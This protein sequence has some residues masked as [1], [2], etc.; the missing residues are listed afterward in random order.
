[1]VH[2]L[3]RLDILKERLKGHQIVLFLDYD[4]TLTPIADR[5]DQAVL[6]LRMRHV[7]NGLAQNK[8]FHIFIVSGRSM[9]DI[10]QLV[11]INNIVHIG[12]HG[13]E[14]EGTDLDFE[15]FCF[16]RFR[17]I[18]EYLKW[19]INKELVFFKGAFVEDKG[20]GLSV[21]YRLL[22]LKDESIFKTFL[23]VIT[24]EFIARGEIC[25]TQGK[26]VFEIR[27]PLDWN[28]GKAVT[29]ILEKYRISNGKQKIVPVYIGDDTTD[30]DAF[31]ALKDMGITVHVGHPKHSHAQYYLNDTDEVIE[32]LEHC[33]R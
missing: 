22:N 2:L 8:C 19:E 10:K 1:M 21:H 6:S 27:A 16:S 30:E 5:P 28:K 17:E 11:G 25:I 7:L 12:N 4:G 15:G 20:L 14:I 9:T 13:F 31:L 18:L 24:R 23:E 26:K 33:V 29:W 32:F 3:K